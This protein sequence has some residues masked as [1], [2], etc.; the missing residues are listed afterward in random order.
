MTYSSA[1]GGAGHRQR[2]D[3]KSGHRAH[4]ER[5]YAERYAAFS[6]R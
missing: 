3:R 4:Y 5:A 1:P 6:R 2:P